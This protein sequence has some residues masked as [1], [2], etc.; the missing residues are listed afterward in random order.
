MLALAPPVGRAVELPDD[1]HAAQPQRVREGAGHE[2]QLRAQAMAAAGLELGRQKADG[3]GGGGEG[4]GWRV[5]GST[6]RLE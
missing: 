3:G 1:E 4:R 2:G 5:A 6:P